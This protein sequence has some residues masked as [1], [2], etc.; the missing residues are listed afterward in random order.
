MSECKICLQFCFQEWN[1]RRQMLEWSKMRQWNAWMKQ[2]KDNETTVLIIDS[3]IYLRVKYFALRIYVIENGHERNTIH[4][5]LSNITGSS[6]KS[7]IKK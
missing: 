2:K 7:K 4:R 6:N 3:Y 1:E 5:S